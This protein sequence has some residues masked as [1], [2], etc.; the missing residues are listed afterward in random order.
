MEVQ[1]SPLHMKYTNWTFLNFA[2]LMCKYH[3]IVYSCWFKGIKSI[4]DMKRWD[5]EC[6]ISISIDTRLEMPNLFRMMM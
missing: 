2:N 4:G 3:V 1:Q 5:I 6:Y